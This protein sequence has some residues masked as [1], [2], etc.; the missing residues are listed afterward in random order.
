MYNVRIS[1]ECIE[2]HT[3][4][5]LQSKWMKSTTAED[6]DSDDEGFEKVKKKKEVKEK[7]EKEEKSNDQPQKRVQEQIVLTEEN[8]RKKMEEIM[9]MRGKKG[10]VRGPFSSFLTGDF[11]L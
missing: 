3:R 5:R 4:M 11:T 1:S 6:S 8:V 2:F 10:T 7:K 9:A